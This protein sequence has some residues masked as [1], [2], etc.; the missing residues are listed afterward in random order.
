MASEEMRDEKMRRDHKNQIL[1]QDYRAQ[2]NDFE[3]AQQDGVAGRDLQ[4]RLD[5]AE[6]LYRRCRD[7][8]GPQVAE[9]DGQL[10]AEL[11]GE[12]YRGVRGVGAGAG[13]AT[14]KPADF[15]ALLAAAVDQAESPTPSD[16][17]GLG[18]L[19]APVLAPCPGLDVLLGT[20]AAP[21]LPPPEPKP[22]AQR[23]RATPLA[24]SVAPE[25]VVEV[26]SGATTQQINRLE[27]VLNKL[28]ARLQRPIG[29]FE[30]AY[31]PDDFGIT[32]E[33]VFHTSIL[34]KLRKARVYLK[35]GLPVIEPV[36]PQ[37]GAGPA[38]DSKY[39]VLVKID[40]ATWRQVVEQ[41]GI[42][43]RLIPRP[44]AISGAR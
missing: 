16:W 20:L 13:P 34:V 41:F 44:D 28:C 23:A 31:D 33:N 39:Q 29:F 36:L 11:A 5:D 21:N 30:F 12:L 22:R 18:K 10:V 14:F 19:T 35:N 1:V 26:E 42:K 37:T 9:V 38:D 6:K 32:V 43:K 3:A 40:H 17:A 25:K 15:A 24:A 8:P 4:R 27:S 7:L 2:I